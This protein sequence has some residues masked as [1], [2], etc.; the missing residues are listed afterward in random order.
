VVR[1]SSP[2]PHREARRG[3]LRR[4]TLW[5]FIYIFTAV[6]VAVG[7]AALLAWFVSRAGLPYLETWLVLALALL[8]LPALALAIRELV[9][10]PERRK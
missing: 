6:A 1:R 4:V 2:D 9:Q 10:R 3:I 5:T 7:G 8:L